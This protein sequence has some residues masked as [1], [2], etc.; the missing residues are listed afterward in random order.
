MRNATRNIAKLV[1]GAFLVALLLYTAGMLRAQ[2]TIQGFPAA[3]NDTVLLCTSS[4]SNATFGANHPL[5]TNYSW[6]FANGVPAAINGIGPHTVNFT[7]TGVHAVQVIAYVGIN[8]V[9]TAVQYVWLG[10]PSPTTFIPPI[11]TVCIS[12]P[13]SNLGAGTPAGGYL[14]GQGTVNG[15]FDPSVAG[16]GTHRIQ[17]NVQNAL[18]TDTASALI[19]VINAPNAHL[20]AQ[21]TP[22]LFNGQLTYTRCVPSSSIFNFYSNTPA[23]SYTGYRINFG[24][25][26]P[27][28]T[29]VSFPS[30]VLPHSYGSTGIYKVALTLIGGNGC[31]STDTVT[32]FYG[33]NPSVGLNITG[34]NIQCLPSDSSGITFWFPITNIS[35][36][37]PGTYY[38]VEV[39]DGS[40]IRTFT[41]PPPDSIYHTFYEPSCGY[42]TANFQNAFQIK[43]TAVTPCA[44]NSVA[45]VEPILVSDPPTAA[46]NADPRIC[47]GQPA[48]IV[49][50]SW[51]SMN[52]LTGCDTNVLLYWE[53]SP[54]TYVLN[55]G[56]LGSSLGDPNPM[57][58]IP[59]SEALSVNFTRTGYYTIRQFVGNQAG[60]EVDT[61]EQVICV[62]SI[63]NP[64]F[65][66]RP[67]TICSPDTLNAFFL[68][69]IKTFCDTTELLWTINPP[70]GHRMLG[71]SD[72]SILQAYFF[73]SGIY[74]VNIFSNNHCDTSNYSRQFI[75]QGPPSL[76]MPND[77]D[78]CGVRDIDFSQNG[79]RP[80][81]YDS[82]APLTFLWK[83]VPDTGWTYINGTDS[84][85]EFPHIDFTS[86]GSYQVLHYLD[87]AC[88][89]VDGFVT[90]T[91]NENPQHDSIADTVVCYGSDFSITGNAFG[92]T[93][94]YRYR[95]RSI[96]SGAVH[97]NGDSL[98][99]SNLLDT[100]TI[101]LRV[102]DHNGCRTDVF[103]T[104]N[105][106]D[107]LIANAGADQTLCHTD[108][109]NLLGSIT[110]GIAPYT[111][112]W[113]PSTKLSSDTVLN[114]IRY[115]HDST[116]TYT[117]HVTDAIGCT[118]TD[119][120]TLVIHQ[121]EPIDAGPDITFCY[122]S[123]QYPLN[124]A[125]HFGGTWVG[126]GM[127]DSLFD[128]IAAGLG[129]HVIYY[130]YTNSQGC[131]YSDSLT[132][133]VINVPTAN[134]SLDTN[135]G[136]S[137]LTI[138]A[139]DSSTVG[140]QHFWYLNNVLVDSVANPQFVLTNLSTTNDSI[141]QVKLI[142]A[143]GSGCTDSSIQM[144]TIHPT[145]IA[146]FTLPANL[147]A[148]DSI[149]VI[150]TSQ[151]N[152]SQSYIWSI[153]N[154]TGTISDS[155]STN[156]FIRFADNQS[157][158]DS[159]YTVT[160][161]MITDDGCSDTAQQSI[162]IY[163]RPVAAFTLP[164]AS[165]TPVTIQPV[166]S[167]SGSGISHQW[168][169]S[170]FVPFTGNTTATPTFMIPQRSN[171]SIVYRIT[172][173]LTNAN[174]CTDTTVQSYTA[175][176][177]PTAAFTPSVTD[178]CGP[179]TVRFD[180]FSSAN[181]TGMG[182]SDLTFA[183][184]FG[185]GVT[186]TDSFPSVTYTNTGLTDSSFIISLVV[187]TP[188][189]C[190]DTL[191]DTVT[192]HPD[193]RAV[194]NANFTANCAP[195]HID[196][197]VATATH[198]NFANQ[199]YYWQFV[200]M[201][202]FVMKQDTGIQNFTYDLLTANDSI[203]LQLIVSSPFGCKM[204]TARQLFYTIDNP[205]A[206]FTPVP[207]SGCSPLTVNI[208]DSSSAGAN[209]YWYV[210]GVLDTTGAAPTFTFINNSQT[211]D[212]IYTIKLV[213]QA[214]TGCTD[215][216][217]RTVVVHPQP[218]AAFNLR[219]N[220][221]PWDTV[222]T[223]NTSSYAVGSTFHWTT[224]SS[225]AWISNP[226][227]ASPVIVF[228]N[229]QSG[230]DSTYRVTLEITSPF[231]CIDTVSRI[232]DIFSRPTAN[233]SVPA[234]ACA[235]VAISPLDSS[236]GSNLT[237]QWS[238]FP[239][240][241]ISGST[242]SNPAFNF[243]ASFSDSV[244]YRIKLVL[245]DSLFGCLDSMTR[246]YTV[247]PR[248][249]AGFV[250]ASTD[251]CPPYTVRITN[252]SLTN[253]TGLN[254]SSMSFLWSFGT[255]QTSTD[256]VPNFTFTNN[257]LSD[258]T[259]IIQLIATNSFGCSDTTIDSVVVHPEPRSSYNLVRQAD[260]AP[261]TIDS[262]VVAHLP[263]PAANSTHTW[264]VVNPNNMA[265]LASYTHV[266]SISYLLPNPGD[267]VI[268]RLI[269]Y[270]P[271][272]CSTDTASTLMFAIGQSFPGFTASTYEGCS[273]LTVTFTDTVPGFGNWSWFV[274]NQLVSNSQ[275]LL[276]TFTNSSLTQ[277][278]IYKVTL[279]AASTY[280]C[281][282][283][284]TQYI[285]VRAP[286]QTHFNFVNSCIGDSISFS[287]STQSL[288]NISTWAWNFGDG[289][290]DT[291]ANPSHLYAN[292][293]QF[294]VSLTT[295][296]IYGCND[297]YA[298]TI[299]VYPKP[300]ASFTASSACGIDTLCKDQNFTIFDGTTIAPFGG[301]IS[302]WLWDYGIDGTI[303]DTVQNP[304]HQVADTG[305]FHVRLTVYTE[306]GCVDTLD[307]TFYINEPPSAGFVIDSIKPCGPFTTTVTNQSFG[308]INNTQWHVY[309]KDTAGSIINIYSSN[310]PNPNPLPTFYPNFGVD[311]TYYI[312]Q[313]V[314][315]CC[316]SSTHIDSITIASMPIAKTIPSVSS[317]CTPLNVTFQ[318]DGLVFGR[319]DYLIFDY[320]DGTIDTVYSFY[321]L[322]P[323][324]DTI[325][326]WGQRNHTFVN[327]NS[328]DTTYTV[329]LRAINGCGDSTVN[330][331]ILVHPS[332]VQAFIQTAPSSGC[333]PLTVDIYDVS[334]GGTTTL[335]CLDYNT[336]TG[337]CN[338]PTA[339]GDS[340]KYTYYTPGTY[341]IAQFVSDGCSADTAFTTVTVH[342]S[343]VAAFA[344]TGS[345]CQ[346]NAVIFT[347]N[348][349]S[350][351]LNIV[352]YNWD[353]GDGNST[354]LPSPTH[355]YT[356]P[357]IY[358]VKLEVQTASGCTDSAF[359]TVTI[360]DDPEMGFVVHNTCFNRQPV[361]F[362]DTSFV[363][364]G[365]LVGTQW[366][367]GDGNTSVAANPTHSYSAPGI[368]TVTLIHTS[369]YG[370]SDSTKQVVNIFPSS[371]A[372]FNDTR[373]LGKKCG[374]P[375]TI[376]FTNLSTAAAGY[377]WD[378]DY[379][380]LRGAYTSTLVNPSFTYLTEGTYDVL[381]VA[382][383][384]NGCVDSIIKPVYIRPYPK[385]GFVGDTFAG[386]APLTISFN[387]TS[388]YA[389]SGPGGIT[390]W[391]WDFGDGT[392]IGG[393]P[394]PTHTY[395]LPGKYQ[396]TL[397]VQN[398]GGCSDT[399]SYD[400]YIDVYPTPVASFAWAEI[401]SKTF[402]FGNT[403]QF[404]D[405]PRT[406]YFWTFGDGRVSYDKH[407][408]H[409]YNVDLFET[410][411][412]FDVCLYVTNPHGCTDTFC[413]TVDLKGYLLFTPNA[414]VP[415]VEGAGQAKY[416]LPAGHSMKEYHLYIFDEWGNILFESTSID[417]NGIPNE[418]W[419][420]THYKTG[421]LLPMGAYVWRIDATFND[422]TKW[423]G[424]DASKKLSQPYGTV[425]LIR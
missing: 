146:S 258:T 186:S 405:D 49:D 255:S 135:A 50:A 95:W 413:T 23:G 124:Q 286:I 274:N 125:S 1:K 56:N 215:S 279:V 266:D 177:L 180:N 408:K 182:L 291:S 128:P 152:G 107:P 32:I 243:P 5:A 333:A 78:F 102:I 305:L 321:Q 156:P 120:V 314:S 231:G 235:P 338:Q 155:T 88:G 315:N 350:N 380:G 378:F 139:F 370:C 36:N 75:V 160:L 163:S 368:Y 134:F 18:C 289:Q 407:P 100:T 253:Q 153:T 351:G 248:P 126:A 121:I 207:D 22:T 130:Y 109:S 35:S 302:T 374:A 195:F 384:V 354:F 158:F 251:S 79:F 222:F 369:S 375:Q 402:N 29:G 261:F 389:F 131:R 37:P 64:D 145:P 140:V 76:V 348:S 356:S 316:G 208:L 256:S 237:Y 355:Y 332:N 244:V 47:I 267:S 357:G 185:N 119:D 406:Q 192:V 283:S 54:S 260:C 143:A 236:I 129:S 322:N 403:T 206:N 8:P 141:V 234:S 358:T 48:S 225:T 4:S 224:N 223:N 423:K 240:A 396:V 421:K 419:D 306:F 212:S 175:Y 268:L 161:I 16:I 214:G 319:P 329:G 364:F 25:G 178:S 210:N 26:S 217:Q 317:G 149:Q 263:H 297:T 65:G 376:F 62:D 349:S 391:H 199:D 309:V 264:E 310:S 252:T 150:N 282:D 61:V 14:T 154:S 157:G 12:E 117:L 318:L 74:D 362:T 103:F 44:P 174:G 30:P 417:E 43:I 342:P 59:G 52:A 151:G 399:I 219:T 343:P 118:A 273:P 335:W 19:T 122:D 127:T 169:I 200:D 221:C 424:A 287:D 388:H 193:P 77:D 218:Q 365:N 241:S 275:N 296:N 114:P 38:V 136:C 276:H 86:H 162:T 392:T 303:D 132:V 13:P 363:R 401:N 170:P 202:G 51:G 299:T 190:T 353:F 323:V 366:K 371:N 194:I 292:P 71:V 176:P 239:P 414:F 45:T 166:D 46:F 39:S 284:V 227:T 11:T 42:N 53:I 181:Q 10:S 301:N 87:N 259:Y 123:I 394:N 24:D 213:V 304:V 269:S 327:P 300:V 313:T 34:N 344:H 290:T 17:Y 101:R 278:S 373:P 293:G 326:V 112:Y 372:D 254:R 184:D 115:P 281:A 57:N 311:T 216:I 133:N 271:Y 226:W 308:T 220:A 173:V 242:S 337:T 204:D 272:N 99:L 262:A 91:F 232:I 277:D 171:D 33:S 92:G 280:G 73:R 415:G 330:V 409:T 247:Y 381:L 198:Y 138:Q 387:D 228:A 96:P 55:S 196:T 187:T 165:C 360:Y 336:A 341:T 211:Q 66:M 28:Q 312:S 98:Y 89:Y 265:I 334:F 83:V 21:G 359:G 147:C 395:L 106:R 386:C 172:L 188:F 111:Y 6:T 20:A 159:T 238:V 116:V 422:G 113:T 411:Y 249:T 41:H 295:T 81:T 167:S 93:P 94:G 340:I 63:P 246:I 205:V 197:A 3:T 324:G 110:G 69:E 90:Y 82:L 203:Y 325:W 230:T 385:A 288:H 108:T 298:D 285:T 367:F 379:N 425:T 331:N 9:D 320:G 383:N 104:I 229:N 418:P 137:Q 70:T 105:V 347:N 27:V 390:A 393:T 60:C 250:L 164:A 84:T 144:V 142:I 72:D 398:D 189:G 346:G 416:F 201:Q 233:F 97:H 58:W 68:N 85:S 400:N 307:R 404:T 183:W 179:L 270:S 80:T 67:D 7:T 382:Y 352:G 345:V 168:S 377:Y 361:A 245:Q 412:I 40:P 209:K 328:Q 339:I 410:D 31:E 294:T 15:L 420:G 397:I 191:T 257:G 2:V 148:N